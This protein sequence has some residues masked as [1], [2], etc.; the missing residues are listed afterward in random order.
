M[1][2]YWSFGLFAMARVYIVESLASL[3]ICI[4]SKSLASLSIWGTGGF[5]IVFFQIFFKTYKYFYFVLA[6]LFLKSA[7]L[8]CGPRISGS[9]VV[10]RTVFNQRSSSNPDSKILSLPHISF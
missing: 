5:L 8:D 9:A 7:L 10:C 6:F 2:E 1:S 3:S 4:L